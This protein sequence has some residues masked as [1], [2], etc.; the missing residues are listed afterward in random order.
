MTQRIDYL[1]SMY[2]VVCPIRK[3]IASIYLKQETRYYL[4]L[5]QQCDV[6]VF[7]AS[8]APLLSQ[9]FRGR[10]CLSN[11]EESSLEKAEK[12]LSPNNNDDIP[13]LI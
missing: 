13:L 11:S 1:R 10:G 9:Y 8:S 3:A 5:D 7:W 4:M 2:S 12:K 6:I